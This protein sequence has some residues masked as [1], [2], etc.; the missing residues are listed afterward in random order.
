METGTTEQVKT[1]V[2]LESLGFKTAAAEVATLVNKKRKLALA[3]EHYRFVRQDKI[4]KFNYE[5][6]RKTVKDKNDPYNM[7]YQML[8]FVSIG[9][10]KN[11]PPESVLASLETAQGRKCFDAYEIGYI[12]NV[13]DPLL[14]GRVNE[15]P[16]RFFIDQW[17]DDVSID[18]LLKENE[19]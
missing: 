13:K 18:Q 9:D 1:A 7:S 4:D 5:L 12:K 6:K 14:F 10:Y 15:C 16:D 19:G 11:V 8:A 3:Y 2:R 17:D